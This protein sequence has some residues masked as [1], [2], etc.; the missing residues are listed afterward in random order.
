MVAATAMPEHRPSAHRRRIL[1]VRRQTPCRAAG[2][3]SGS[4]ASEACVVVAD[5]SQLDL[6]QPRKPSKESLAKWLKVVALGG[7][8]K[9]ATSTG[10]LVQ[11][12]K[13]G[14]YTPAECA[15]DVRFAR[16]HAGLHAM[17]RRVSRA[18]LSRWVVHN[19]GDP[20][21]PKGKGCAQIQSLHDLH[22]FLCKMR[23]LPLVAGVRTSYLKQDIVTKSAAERQLRKAHLMPASKAKLP[24]ARPRGRWLLRTGV[25]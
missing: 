25:R 4:K 8:A 7:Q 22:Q 10:N 2:G 17:L 5:E 11:H 9:C 15:V 18:A 3:A 19:A 21:T 24:V 6:T 13:P 1:P 14:I 16:K 20:S 12:H 23:A